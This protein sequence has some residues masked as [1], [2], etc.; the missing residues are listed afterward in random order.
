[1]KYRTDME[2]YLKLYPEYEK[3]YINECFICH[4]K[5]CKPDLFERTG[6]KLSYTAK[7]ITKFFNRLELNEIGICE[8]CA[9]F[10]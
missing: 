10:Y 4:M 2:Y 9:K 3:L 1:M 7:R 6:E 8:Q 5:G